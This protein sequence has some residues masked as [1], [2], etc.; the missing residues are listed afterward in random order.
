MTASASARTLDA[1]RPTNDDPNATTASADARS[2]DGS[3]RVI[4]ANSSTIAERGRRCARPSGS[5]RSSGPNSASVNATFSPDTASRC[6]SPTPGTRRPTSSGTARVSPSRKPASSARG[7]GGSGAVPRSTTP[8]RRFAT[9]N[10]PRAGSSPST[11]TRSKRPTACRHWRA[12]RSSIG[13]SGPRRPRSTTRSPA[14]STRTR[15]ASSPVATDVQRAVRAADRHADVRGRCRSG[16]VCGSSTRTP[17]IVAGA[18]RSIAA[19]KRRVRETVRARV[20]SARR[21]A[22]A[23]ATHRDHDAH[24]PVDEPCARERDDAGREDEPGR[25]G[26]GP[27]ARERCPARGRRA[28]APPRARPRQTVDEVVQLREPPRRRCRAR[29]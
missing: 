1:G 7:V 24:A 12:A 28:R 18:L 11:S 25:R 15:S 10:T 16:R 3:K 26:P 2:T 14:S 20:A 27:F 22:S 23:S 5:R 21:R 4:V 9:R 17:A 8:R 29:G 6:D 19:V 13:C